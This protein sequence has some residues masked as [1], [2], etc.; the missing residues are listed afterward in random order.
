MFWR[1]CAKLWT[2]L[3]IYIHIGVQQACMLSLS[4]NCHAHSTRAPKEERLQQQH[5]NNNN[6]NNKGGNNCNRNEFVWYPTMTTLTMQ[7][8]RFYKK[9]QKARSKQRIWTNK[10]TGCVENTK[11]THSQPVLKGGGIEPQASAVDFIWK[12]TIQLAKSNMDIQLIYKWYKKIYIY[13][14]T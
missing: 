3:V 11:P 1:C 9:H 7:S 12:I 5:C 13:I 8:K 14:N 2:V 10:E 6:N 4:K